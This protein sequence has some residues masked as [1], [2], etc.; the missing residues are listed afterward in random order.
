MFATDPAALREAL[1]AADR[2]RCS[3]CR[4]D[5]DAVLARLRPLRSH[6]EALR[7]GILLAMDPR[8]GLPEHALRLQRLLDT[9]NPGCAQLQ[10]GTRSLRLLV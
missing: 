5:C 10:P 2:G 8:F 4:L 9:C 7:R 6:P 1:H 3:V